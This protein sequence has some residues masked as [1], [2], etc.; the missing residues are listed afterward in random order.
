MNLLNNLYSIYYTLP[1][2]SRI[3]FLG[4]VVN[5][6]LE[7]SLKRVFDRTVPSYLDRTKSDFGFG[8][9]TEQRKETFIASLTSFPARINDIW[10]TLELLLRQTFKPDK[11]ILWLSKEQFPGKEK[12]LPKNVN[13]LIKRGLIIE[14]VDDDLKAHKKYFYAM[15]KYPNANIITLDDDLYYD[16]NIIKNVVKLHQKYPDL[17]TTNRAHKIT[18]HNGFINKYK[19]WKHRVT[20]KSPSKAILPTGGG[21]TLYPPGSLHPDAF[22]SNLIKKLSLNADDI[23]LKFMSLKNNRLSVTNKL[24]NKQFI[25]VQRTQ[26]EKLVNINIGANGNDIQ[27]K[28]LCEYYQIDFFSLVNN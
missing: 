23:W 20:D 9:N 3:G 4:K 25:T 24:Y 13:D 21:G 12:D 18:F 6:I 5:K 1:D 16:T 26:G 2:F 28:N 22:N 19:N 7:I 11:L 27:L 14:W 17:I 8:L 15:Q 10:I